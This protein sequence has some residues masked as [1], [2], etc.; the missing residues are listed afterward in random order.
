[1]AGSRG[2][3]ESVRLLHRGGGIEAASS[4]LQLRQDGRGRVRTNPAICRPAFPNPEKAHGKWPGR[5]P[6]RRSSCGCSKG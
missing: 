3:S 4:T 1:M 6:F 5:V 2:G